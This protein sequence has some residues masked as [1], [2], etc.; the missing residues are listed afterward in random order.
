MTAFG[1]LFRTTAIKLSLLYLIVFSA[2]TGFVLVYISSKTSALLSKTLETTIT[3]DLVTLSD[4]YMSGG[5]RRL[6]ESVLTRSRQPGASLYLVKDFAGRTVVANVGDIQLTSFSKDE[7]GFFPIPYHRLEGDT[8][9]EHEALAR[10]MLLPGGVRLLVG[11]D[12]GERDAFGDVIK[13]ALQLSILVFVIMGFASWFIVSRTVLR[14]VESVAETSNQ[15]MSGDLSQRLQIV[16]SGDEFDNLAR[17]LN[18][19]L[20]RIEQLMAGLKEV[21][22]NIAHD[23]RTPLTRLRTRLETA[24][25]IASDPEATREAVA[26]S[27][28]DADALIATFDAL[29][30]IARVEAG[31]T[32]DKDEEVDAA[33][34]LAD[35]AE[36]YEPA[37]E[38]I[39]GHLEIDVE[40]PLPIEAS[41]ALVSQAIVNL[42]DNALKYAFGEE[43]DLSG[44]T[45]LL[46]LVGRAENGH[47][48]LSV[49]DNGP[50]IPAEDRQRVLQR[51]VRLDVSRS[52]PGSGLGLALV[53]AVAHY[54]GGRFKLGDAEPGLAATLILP[55]SGRK[56]RR[57]TASGEEKEEGK[58]AHVGPSAPERASRTDH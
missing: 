27:V 54:Y 34:I 12:V 18:A 44:R 17:S 24:L 56:P 26:A 5:I 47:I 16:G 1:K 19:M 28:E 25:V 20:D 32:G 51:F 48:R 31:S 29:L 41:R 45:P 42:L 4:D 40:G 21:S 33:A 23:L 55:E 9:A 37:L 46:R 3:A 36:L 57:S 8:V 49:T 53:S 6:V 10:V 14:R 52:R 11:R 38:D 13:D 50:G 43:S 30:K 7:S 39:D 22:D 2:L 58:N 15:I 35:L